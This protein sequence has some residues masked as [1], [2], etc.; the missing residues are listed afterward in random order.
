MSGYKTNQRRVV[1]RGRQF[2]FVSYEGVAANPRLGSDA[3]PPTWF[4]MSSGKRWAVMPQDL[5]QPE[6]EL[7]LR[8]H[9]WLDSHVF[10]ISLP[11]TDPDRAHAAPRRRERARPR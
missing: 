4:L 11:V 8:L 2:H 7:D 9:D 10:P 3:S 5:D 1:H 6:A